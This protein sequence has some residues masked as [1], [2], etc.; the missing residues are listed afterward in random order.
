MDMAS[1]DARL[2]LLSVLEVRL[3]HAAAKGLLHFGTVEDRAY[4]LGS[5]LVLV[6]LEVHLQ[7]SKLLVTTGYSKG[8]TSREAREY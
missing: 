3:L 8:M 5:S 4:F 2:V 1:V 6:I 7:T